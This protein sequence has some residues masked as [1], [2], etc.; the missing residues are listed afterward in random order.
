M[1]Q[2]RENDQPDGNGCLFTSEDAVDGIL[3]HGG[4]NHRV[5]REIGAGP[6]FVY[7]PAWRAENAADTTGDR[8][9][10]D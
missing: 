1:G 3:E 2:Q 9:D 6:G 5:A 7:L 10:D 8:A 4:R